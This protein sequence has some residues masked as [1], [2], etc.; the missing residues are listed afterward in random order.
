MVEGDKGETI[1]ASVQ[2]EADELVK[3]LDQNNNGT[4]TKM[5]WTTVFGSLY[6]KVNESKAKKGGAAAVTAGKMPAS[7]NN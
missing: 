3:A 4:V 6:E 2:K 1:D 5:E 7:K